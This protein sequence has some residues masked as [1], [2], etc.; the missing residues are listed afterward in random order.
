L[1]VRA[2]EYQSAPE[3][4]VRPSAK[5]FKIRWVRGMA[6]WAQPGNYD[7]TIPKDVTVVSAIVIGGGGHGVLTEGIRSS[8]PSY[9]QKVAKPMGWG[10]R[11]RQRMEKL[12]LVQ[13]EVLREEEIFLILARRMI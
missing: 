10:A 12:Q 5:L 9:M 6:V 3:P 2:L 7:W 4:K 1:Y 11:E 13:K 8:V